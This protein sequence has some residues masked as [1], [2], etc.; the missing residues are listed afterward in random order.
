[1][2]QAFVALFWI[3]D[4]SHQK[5]KNVNSLHFFYLSTDDEFQDTKPTPA[6]LAKSL[7]DYVQDDDCKFLID[8]TQRFMVLRN[9]SWMS[10]DLCEH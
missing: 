4:A 8:L 10:F 6:L 3:F 7:E 5:I 2:K 1:M 9:Q